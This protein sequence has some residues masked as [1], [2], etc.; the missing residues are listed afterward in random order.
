[1][2]TPAYTRTAVALHWVMAA[3]VLGTFVLGL[4]MLVE[5]WRG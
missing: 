1:M 2:S 3:L 4:W 5:H